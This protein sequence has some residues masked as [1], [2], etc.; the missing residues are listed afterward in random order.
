MEIKFEK[1]Q[2]FH[3]FEFARG[4]IVFRGII[5]WLI[6]KDLVLMSNHSE[7]FRL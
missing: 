5:K 4:E 3:L 7:I 2:I 6:R 1:E